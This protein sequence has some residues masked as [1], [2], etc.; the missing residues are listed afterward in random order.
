MTDYDAANAAKKAGDESYA[1]KNMDVS[2]A[3]SIN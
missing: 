3:I 1:S 2:F